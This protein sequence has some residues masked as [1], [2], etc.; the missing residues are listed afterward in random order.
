MAR[1]GH[2]PA[3]SD[4]MRLGA[5]L[6]LECP[7]RA[8]VAQPDRVVASE[9]IGRGFESLRARHSCCSCSRA[10]RSAVPSPPWLPGCPH[11][12][13]APPRALPNVADVRSGC[14]CASPVRRV[15]RTGASPTL[16]RTR[17]AAGARTRAPRGVAQAAGRRRGHASARERRARRHARCVGRR[18]GRSVFR[19]HRQPAGPV[20]YRPP[21]RIRGH[22]NRLR[23]QSSGRPVRKEGRVE[24]HAGRDVVADADRGVHAR[25]QPPGATRPSAHRA[26]ARRWHRSGWPTL[27]RHA[28]GA[29]HRHGPLGGPA[30]AVARRT[31]PPAPA[32][33]SGAAVCAWARHAAPGHQAGQ[34]AGIGGRPR[35]SHRLRPVRHDGQPGRARASLHRGIQ[36]I[37]RAGNTRG[38][39]RL[40]GQRHLFDRRH[41]VPAPRRRLAS[42]A[43]AAAGQPHR[44]AGRSSRTASVAAGDVDHDGRRMEASLPQ[45]GATGPRPARRPG[46]HRPQIRGDVARGSLRQ[47]RG[48][49]RR[50]GA[51]AGALPGARAMP[52]SCMRCNA[53]C[54]A[55][56]C[57]A[58]WPAAW[59]LSPPRPQA[60]WAGRS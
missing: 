47:R 40:R 46:C 38:G 13:R 59:S 7:S 29:R 60:C 58:H 21:A 30:A 55:T 44:L 1:P 43:A 42:S 57:P 51:L 5:G 49:D 36:W 37:Y 39:R 53:S 17:A 27:V 10:V 2:F 35:A 24:V 22:G 6:R 50:H 18:G 14:P 3:P 28:P 33:L 45:P 26:L 12:A 32:S 25:T 20:A 34:P 41:A 16:G 23:G 48:P 19:T 15:R 11:P 9:A 54:N 4:D 56:P 52:A 31:R 8:P